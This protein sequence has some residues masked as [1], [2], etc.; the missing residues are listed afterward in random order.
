[1]S[2]KIFKSLVILAAIVTIVTALLQS[3]SVLNVSLTS[4]VTITAFEKLVFY[5]KNVY[6]KIFDAITFMFLSFFLIIHVFSLPSVFR[7]QSRMITMAFC[8][9]GI[10]SHQFLF[11]CEI[12]SQ[13]I[14]NGFSVSN[15]LIETVT[16]QSLYNFVVFSILYILLLS[17]KHHFLK[18]KKQLVY[19][20]ILCF[21][22]LLVLQMANDISTG[23]VGLMMIFSVFL[24]LASNVSQAIVLYAAFMKRSYSTG[25]SSHS[26]KEHYG[27]FV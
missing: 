1:M 20:A 16:N 17:N 21:L 25:P 19:A 10:L 3:L 27:S 23:N 22:V 9:L 6:V 12:I 14:K 15:T 8:V 24:T 13:I 7:K 5:F 4:N 26:N 18:I 11:I 2:K